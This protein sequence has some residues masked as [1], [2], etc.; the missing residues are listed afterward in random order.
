MRLKFKKGT[1][2]IHGLILGRAVTGL[3]AFTGGK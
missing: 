2:D 3:Q 1:H